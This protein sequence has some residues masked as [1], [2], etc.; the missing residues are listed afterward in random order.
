[1]EVGVGD[2]AVRQ[3][4]RGQLVEGVGVEE[5]KLASALD[6]GAQG[7]EAAAGIEA[8]VLDVPGDATADGGDLRIADAIEH[9]LAKFAAARMA[10]R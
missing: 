5:A 6:V 8:D 3:T 4:R 7:E 9:Q 1:M 2:A 10:P